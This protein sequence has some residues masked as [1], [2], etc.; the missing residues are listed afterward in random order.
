[1]IRNPVMF[2]VEVVAALTTVIFVRDL[3]TH[4]EHLGFTFQIILWLWITVLFANL[5]EAVA[6]GRGKAQADAYAEHGR[7]PLPSCCG[8]DATAHSS[9]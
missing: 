9:T 3:I 2:V 5:A 8:P 1:M 4:G 6:E 7:N